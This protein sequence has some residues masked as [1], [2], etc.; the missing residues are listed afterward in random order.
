MYT[1]QSTLGKSLRR[2]RPRFLLAVTVL[3]ALLAGG[4]DAL[5]QLSGTYTIDPSGSGST[6]YTTFESAISALNSNGV[7]GP[8][9]FRIA[10]G[11]YV[12]TTSYTFG[13]VT[14]MSS[15]NTVTFKPATG[16]TVI[17]DATLT[18]PMFDI[19]QGDNFIFDGSNASGGTTR[20]WKVINRG[21][22][23]A[24]RLINGATNNT[25]KNMNL[26]G[27]VSS[28]TSTGIVNIGNSSATYGV[29]NANNLISSNTLGDSSGALRSNNGIYMLGDATY[30]N[31]ANRLDN[32][33]IFNLG[34]TNGYF[35][36]IYVSSYNDQIKIFRNRIR[37][38][39]KTNTSGVYPLYGVYFSN[40]SSSSANGGDTI[41][42][43]QIYDLQTLYA[44]ATQYGIYISSAGSAP[45]TIHN[46][47]I[48]QISDQGSTVAGV[49]IGTTTPT[50]YVYYNS[51]YISGNYASG[52]TT[53]YNIYATGAT[54][55]IRNNALMNTRVSTGTNTNRALYRASSTGTYSSDYNVIYTS[56]ASTT[57]GYLSSTATYYATLSAWQTASGQ[58]AN[59]AFGNPQ[60]VSPSTG[61]LH[62][63]TTVRT[64][65]ES[66]GTPI[67]GLTTDF[68]GN[69][70]N[71]T[72]P[73]VGA[74]EGSFLPLFNN[75]MAADRFITPLPGGVIPA[76]TSF[77]PVAQVAN[78]GINSQ[79]GVTVRYRIRNASNTI[80]YEDV[81]T[82]GSLNSATTQ[83]ITFGS[84]GSVS[85]STSLAPGTYSIELRT[86]LSSDQD[87]SSDVITATVTARTALCGNYTIDPN[88]SGA[89]NYTSFTAAISDLNSLGI[90]CAVTFTVA[91]G[92]YDATRETFPLVIN[93][94][95]GT[96]ASNRVTFRPATGAAV[97]LDGTSASPLIDL[98]GADNITF[99]GANSTGGTIRNWKV[100]N[101]GAGSAVR[102]INGATNDSVVNMNLIGSVSSSTSTGIVNIGNSSATY[103]VGNINNVIASN[104][105][106]DS[107]GVLRSNNGIYM[108]GDVNYHNVANRIDNNDIF[109]LGYTGGWF[110]GIYVS[111]YNDQIKIF[112]NR[113]RETDKSNTSGVYPCYGV[114]FSNSSSTSAAGN[115]SIAYN[116]IYDLSTQYATATQYGVYITSAGTAPI[117]IHNNMIS[118]YATDGSLYGVY[119]GTSTPTVNIHH[120]SIYIGG[121]N[122]ASSTTSD[123]IYATSATVSIRNNVLVNL[124][125]S[126]G[127]SSNLLLYRSS[128]TGTFTSNN[129][130]LYASGA[131]TGYGYAATAYSTL[132]AWQGAGY[133]L[134]SVSGP[135]PFTDPTN[136]NLHIVNTTAI[137]PGEG[138]GA[139]LGYPLDFDQQARDLVAPDIGADEG[140]FNGGGVRVVYPNGGEQLAVN[141]P[142]TVQYTTNR[143]MNVRIE[144]STNNGLTWVQQG[145]VNP[146]SA[147]SNTFLFMTPDTVT[148][149]MRLRIIS[150]VN[151]IEGDTSDATF[152]LVRPV[153]QVLVPNGG[154]KWV[155]GDTNRIQFTAQ[156]MPPSLTVALDYS[157]NGGA[158][159]LPIA[160]GLSAP[161]LPTINSYNWIT[162]N[163][164]STS[165]LVRVRLP[166][167][168]IGDTSNG[169]F[170]IIPQP[171]VR[172]VTPNGGE[173]VFAGEVYKI[174]WASQTTDYV[175]LE[176]STD[177]GLTWTQI[178]D[179]IAAY[180]GSYDWTVPDVA[181]SQ[182]LV[183]VTNVERPRYSDQSDAMFSIL[184]TN[185]QVLYP[186]GGEKF[187]LNQ[188][189]TVSWA[190]RN[191]TTLRLEFSRDNGATWQVIAPSIPAADGSYTFT[192]N[193]IPSK[194][195]L[196]RLVDVDREYVQDRSDAPFEIMTAKSISVLS[197][198][199]GDQLTRGTTTRIIWESSRI[200]SVNILYSSNGGTTFT[201]IASNIPAA[202]GSLLWNVPNQLTTQGI[203]RIQEVGGAVYGESGRFSIVDAVVST[204]RVITPNGGEKY[205]EGDPINISWTASSDLASVTISYSTNAGSSWTQIISGVPAL[206]G[207][208][209]WRAPNIPGDQYRIQVASGATSDISDNN[210]EVM[211]LLQPKITVTYPNGGENVTGGD[212][213]KITWTEQDITGQVTVAYSIDSGATWQTIN[214]VNAGVMTLDWTVPD[215]A[216]K[217]ALVRVS[218]GA[219]SDLSNLVFEITQKIVR[220]IT[221]TSPNGGEVWTEAESH[222]VTWTSSGLT[223]TDNVDIYYSTDF[224]VSWTV[225]TS[226]VSATAGTIDWT[227]PKLTQQTNSALV[228]IRYTA[229]LTVKDQS[230]NQFTIKV[231]TSGAVPGAIT[232]TSALQLFGNFPNPF[233]TSTT[234]RWVQAGAGDVGVRIYDA[235]GRVVRQYDAGR[236]EAGEQH[237]ELRAGELPSG[238]YQYEVQVGGAVARGM[239]MIVR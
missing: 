108:L 188:P 40:S 94:F 33:D 79:S 216:T 144:L 218:A 203:I 8:V 138:L 48:T 198:G 58:D 102:F 185:L 45:I 5:A 66:K 149:L 32:N 107:S 9:T 202:Q 12:P 159:W 49:Y 88:G 39:D 31:S 176:Y 160:S 165:A 226:S 20:N 223:S 47:M 129:N 214:T 110:Y 92:T 86:E 156:F 211:R 2:N 199:E 181:T 205:T 105:I 194:T 193:A 95:L 34:Y 225:I 153:F 64:P 222:P 127:T 213:V 37:E 18:V 42:Y 85:G 54:V 23:S 146:T 25:V 236:R 195:A 90:S 142:V 115:D 61:D 230:D 137:F 4:S 21:S 87:A 83:Q 112:R 150:Q 234:L 6:N 68:D 55:T 111:S 200:A 97:I 35:Y 135:V 201:T 30:H 143:P 238:V 81:Q 82:T 14:G 65:V 217:N 173:G 229:D 78:I 10:S 76:N 206:S 72:T 154:E 26:I 131:S 141:A 36:G 29:G 215:V 239:M 204:I 187:D 128:T 134:N 109:N 91:G 99:N 22:G 24:L 227:I 27:S 124:R 119:V 73:D 89:T 147:G 177:G 98:S 168:S 221:V 145:V 50:V 172:V 75:D 1:L 106:G 192:P 100:I 60:F 130:L 101:R 16:A 11:T 162:P 233:A 197:P 220:S 126:T 224:G 212:L 164:P 43:N 103:G 59:S 170:T 28:S 196:V 121:T 174:R 77:S 69:T 62:I 71:T 190:S 237:L 133:D 208:Y 122:T 152:S 38:T 52:S 84:T 41:A 125:T 63:S 151:Q 148:N 113:E 189:I 166:N 161:N 209:Q 120:N 228:R 7:S 53:S 139:P 67:S 136:G 184:K 179:R 163:T 175:K 17:M 80:V 57:V 19:N 46:N 210:F 104:T 231:L 116:Q 93:Q 3:I 191:S 117:Y 44:P 15:T 132:A 169:V 235:S 158:T 118:L 219:T 157:T 232:G 178:I 114:Y 74:D 123:N 180:L 182:A 56:G 13:A 155:A 96:S 186:N 51:I 171:F 183:R 167:S 140:N 207:S 70:R